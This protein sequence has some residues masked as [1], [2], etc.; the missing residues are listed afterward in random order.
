MKKYI[1]RIYGGIAI[2]DTGPEFNFNIDNISSDVIYLQ[3]DVSGTF[4]EDGVE[5]VYAYEYNPNSS[6]ADRKLVRTFLKNVTE[7]DEDIY[8]FV[9]NG[10]FMLDKYHRLEEFGAIV[11][12]YS[13][14][15]PSLT[16]VMHDYFAQYCTHNFISFKLLKKAYKDVQFDQAK[17]KDALIAE[18]R[19]EI[20]ANRE[21]KRAAKKF[22]KLKETD[23]LF[24]MKK[25]L[26]RAIRS[27]FS[28]FLKFRSEEEKEIYLSLQ[29]VNVLIYDD[30]L[31]SGA[32]VKEII[33]YLKS[34]NENNTLTVFV[35]V[36]QH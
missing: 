33:R 2:Q 6:Q 29:G 3:K 15:R 13:T 5:Y 35:L 19:T 23:E 16:E 25:F 24:E 9:E 21:V 31:T 11:T 34:F 20:E 17:A 8:E 26:P 12:T 18:G 32:T 7:D 30:F 1:Q 14:N 10:V 22:E 4:N 27:S 36:K 28:N